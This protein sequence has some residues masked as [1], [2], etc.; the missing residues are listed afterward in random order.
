MTWSEPPDS[1]AKESSAG[2]AGAWAVPESASSSND[3][4]VKM[5]KD[6]TAAERPPVSTLN[7]STSRPPAQPPSCFIALSQCRIHGPMVLVTG[8]EDTI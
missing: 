4:A 1:T 2:A 6:M 7:H 5:V 3:R 8:T